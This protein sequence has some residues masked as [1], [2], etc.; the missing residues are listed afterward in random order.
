MERY[1]N[2]CIADHAK[3]AAEKGA[4]AGVV[5]EILAVALVMDGGTA[6]VYAPQA[7]DALQEFLA[8]QRAVE[9]AG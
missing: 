5:T 9:A 1:R 7:R 4:T 6:D 3:A 8:D 2:G